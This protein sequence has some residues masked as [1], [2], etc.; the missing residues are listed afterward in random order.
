MSKHEQDQIASTLRLSEALDGSSVSVAEL[1]QQLEREFDALSS[2]SSLKNVGVTVPSVKIGETREQMLNLV[3]QILE[4]EYAKVLVEAKHAQA[5]YEDEMKHHS[6]VE[7]KPTGYYF[8][9]V[10]A[11][12]SPGSKTLRDGFSISMEWRKYF[13]AG[14]VNQKKTLSKSISRRGKDGKYQT[15]LFKGASEWEKELIEQTESHLY[16]LRNIMKRIS[17]IKR[18][19]VATRDRFT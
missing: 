2:I 16:D 1:S 3:I 17:S 9:F 14:P 19:V 4:V 5:L 8:P 11:R 7:G 15:Y 18:S 10:R 12:K 13:R 6:E